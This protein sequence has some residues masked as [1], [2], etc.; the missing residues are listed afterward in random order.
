MLYFV[1]LTRIE[2]S[3]IVICDITRNSSQAKN[4]FRAT[5]RAF[6]F[7]FTA[8]TTLTATIYHRIEGKIRNI[9]LHSVIYQFFKGFRV[10][11]DA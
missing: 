9:L 4:I 5:F 2:G 6:I 3:S 7:N 8:K 1:N 10:V 11:R